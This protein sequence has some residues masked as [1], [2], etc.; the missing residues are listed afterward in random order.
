MTYLILE[1]RRTR[2]CRS[3][4]R[5]QTADLPPQ[6]ESHIHT[7][8]DSQQPVEGERGGIRTRVSSWEEGVFIWLA[9]CKHVSVPLVSSP[10]SRAATAVSVPIFAP[11]CR[12]TP[13]LPSL[14]CLSVHTQM[15][16]DL[17]PPSRQRLDTL[18]SRCLSG[19]CFSNAL[20]QA[21]SDGDALVVE[22]VLLLGVEKNGKDR[23]G[24][25]ALIRA[26]QRGHM[27]VLRALLRAGAD[28]NMK[29]CS[30]LGFQPRVQQYG[31][32]AVGRGRS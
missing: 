7:C 20:C 8:S 22:A 26:V 29:P 18:I 16:L 3:Q 4:H 23:R 28:V 15:A 5:A 11:D 9:V 19:N 17:P 27:G 24:D 21:A 14:I 12:V 30:A 32:G 13:V 1:K 31:G 10:L 2:F 25:S 6:R